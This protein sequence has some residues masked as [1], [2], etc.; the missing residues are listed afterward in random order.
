MAPDSG[1]CVT[2]MGF[3]K[4]ASRYDDRVIAIVRG[5]YFVVLMAWDSR[6]QYKFFHMIFHTGNAGKSSPQSS[7]SLQVLPSV[8][9]KGAESIYN[10]EGAKLKI[11]YKQ[12]DR[13]TLEEAVHF[14]E[15]HTRAR[16]RPTLKTEMKPS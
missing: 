4:T 1:T 14:Y 9:I 7:H 11:Q 2:S 16:F 15:N 13:K 3:Q 8:S 6:S 5:T 12:T 10:T